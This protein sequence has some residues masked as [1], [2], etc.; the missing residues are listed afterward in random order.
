MATFIDIQLSAMK[1]GDA[2]LNR[3]RAQTILSAAIFPFS[4]IPPDPNAPPVPSLLDHVEFPK[5]SV[6]AIQL[7]AKQDQQEFN[8]QGMPQQNLPVPH[9]VMTVPVRVF[10][11]TLAAAQN[12]DT[13]PGT[14][15]ASPVLEVLVGLNAG[16]GYFW[17]EVIDAQ[18]KGVSQPL[19]AILLQQQS[20]P[21]VGFQFDSLST[22]LGGVNVT[23]MTVTCDGTA[24]LP[25]KK[26]TPAS[27]I[28]V[29]LEINGPAT[30]AADWA[31]YFSDFA[32]IL[33]G[34]DWSLFIDQS[35]IVAAVG[36]RFQG[37]F[38]NLAK[39]NSPLHLDSQ[40][41][42]FWSIFS[43]GGQIV[44]NV[45]AHVD[46]PCP[47]TIHIP[48][49]I[50]IDLSVSNG[51]VVGNGSI[52]GNPDPGD[53][54]LCSLL[55]GTPAS[56]FPGANASIFELV[57]YV[58]GEGQGLQPG[59]ID[60]STGCMLIDKRTFQCTYPVQQVMA[61]GP[62]LAPEIPQPGNPT[63]SLVNLTL[64]PASIVA[65]LNGPFISGTAKVTQL[66]DVQ[67]LS[68]SVTS[69]DPA[70]LILIGDCANGFNAGY[71]I[72][73]EI[74]GGGAL[75][76]VLATPPQVIDDPENIFQQY[77][78]S[79]DSL[80]WSATPVE[81]DWSI[82]AV[83]PNDPYW[84]G[85]N[86]V[87]FVQSS[88][89]T[90][91]VRLPKLAAAT[92][93]QI[94]QLNDPNGAQ[95]ILA[96]MDCQL[97]TKGWNDGGIG[98]NWQIDPTNPAD[99]TIVVENIWTLELGAVVAGEDYQALG[100]DGSL[101]AKAV[102]ME[103]T[104]LLLSVVANG[105]ASAP[106]PLNFT[107]PA[108]SATAG[109][110]GG[111]TGEMRV[112]STRNRASGILRQQRLERRAIIALP[113]P[114]HGLT[115]GTFGNEAVL[116]LG[117]G[118]NLQVVS[119]ANPAAPGLKASVPQAWG[120]M[121]VGS[122]I[123]SWGPQGLK[124]DGVLVDRRAFVQ[125]LARDLHFYG[126]TRHELVVFDV[127][128]QSLGSAAFENEGQMVL[129]RG[130]AVVRSARGLELV[131]IVSPGKPRVAGAHPEAGLVSL[132]APGAISVPTY[133]ALLERKDGSHLV[134]D[135]RGPKPLVIAEYSSRPW[136]ARAVQVDGRL[137]RPTKDST[138]IEV[139]RFDKKKYD[140]F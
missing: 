30:S 15:A 82:K 52:S 140:S 113:G 49:T 86:A 135:F 2:V 83:P 32:P 33:L 61:F 87:L 1:F 11:K 93:Q 90:A 126:L 117:A 94:D 138:A 101:L 108:P 31:A 116:F 133:S 19:A 71:L 84:Q 8:L 73:A 57:A 56:G 27:V 111:D 74:V 104:P 36:N 118:N 58:V 46:T 72:Q 67:S 47:N 29:R 89:G 88:A 100:G 121:G 28:G 102:G 3:L 37:A 112:L 17:F 139:F 6:I 98:P 5:G 120:A 129:I 64:T 103:G 124:R 12:P 43:P 134:L 7:A 78:E 79:T 18:Y 59:Q 136:F 16:P 123:L 35:L 122:G 66:T 132:S 91:A 39:Q 99:P 81:L 60:P 34:G 22:L 63:F 97:L 26:G 65:S 24:D 131:D 130:L 21:I 14:Y 137:A 128:L 44:G 95:M 105:A 70:Q 106:V 53:V 107:N 92:Q 50:T 68:V 96:L 41:V 110:I 20:L 51:N 62:F 75:P 9:V 77:T 40:P 85:Y 48:L 54:A 125:V 55:F 127:H 38:A 23:N 76:A 69:D 114:F 115:A 10:I 45:Q 42:F 25:K 109:M 13:P 119:I 80:T 4:G